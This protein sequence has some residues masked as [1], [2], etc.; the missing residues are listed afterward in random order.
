[1]KQIRMTIC[2]VVANTVQWCS[3]SFA[4]YIAKFMFLKVHKLDK[5]L[6]AYPYLGARHPLLDCLL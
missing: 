4:T 6:T 5:R 1:M 3:I 2:T